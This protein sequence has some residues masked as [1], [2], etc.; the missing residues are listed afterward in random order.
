MVILDRD[1]PPPTS[2][3]PG[4]SVVGC[5]DRLFACFPFRRRS[6]GTD[7]TCPLYI[8]RRD[9]EIDPTFSENC[10]RSRPRPQAASSTYI[11]MSIHPGAPTHHWIDARAVPDS[12]LILTTG[13]GR[14]AS[15]QVFQTMPLLVIY[16]RDSRCV[17]NENS[18]SC[19]GGLSRVN[20]IWRTPPSTVIAREIKKCRRVFPHP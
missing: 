7:P 17:A 3:L 10:F 6:A 15:Q 16:R 4:Q 2:G 11:R 20:P 1:A 19:R 18:F 5:S 8:Y 12:L 9:P 14:K 13:A